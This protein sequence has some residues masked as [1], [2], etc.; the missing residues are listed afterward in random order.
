MEWLDL[1]LFGLFL[2]TFF[3]ATV[4]P[5]SSEAILIGSLAAGFDPITCL[6]VATFGNTLG[7]MTSYGLGYLGDWHKLTKWLR[8]EESEVIRW[9]YLITKYGSYTAILCWLPFVGDIIA[10]ALGL[11]R[12]RIVPTI[13]WMFTGKCLRYIMVTYT[14]QNFF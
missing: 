5:F 3:A 11:F 7:G 9:K 13:F 14:Y 2:A 12:S 1:G 8:V 6:V 10:I 4:L